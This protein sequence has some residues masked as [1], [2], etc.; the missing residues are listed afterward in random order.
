MIYTHWG[1]FPEKYLPGEPSGPKLN[2]TSLAVWVWAGSIQVLQ[3]EPGINCNPVSMAPKLRPRGNSE[4]VTGSSRKEQPHQGA[5]LFL[6]DCLCSSRTLITGMASGSIVAFNIDFNRWHYEHQNRYWRQMKNQK[7]SQSWEHKCF[8]ERQ[9]LW[10]KKLVYIDLRLYIPSHPAIAV[11]CS[12]QP[13]SFV[14]FFT[15]EH[16]LLPSKLI[17]CKLYELG[18]VLVIISYIVVYWEKVVGRVTRDF[19]QFWG[20]LCPVV[21]K[22]KLWT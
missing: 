3:G 7:P 9:Y 19:W 6:N 16:Q 4:M 12:Q 13:F 15:T 14:C 2:N 22:F 1:Y 10:W 17:S 20:T 21:T 5:H 11:H 18:D 8:M